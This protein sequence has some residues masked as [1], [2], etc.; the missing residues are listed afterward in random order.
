MLAAGDFDLMRPYFEMYRRALP[1]ARERCRKFCSHEGAFFPE[2]MWFWGAYLEDNYGWSDTRAPSLPVH[3]SQNQY[4]RRHHSSGLEVAC[5]ALVYYRFTGDTE[6]L[7]GTA[8]PLADA[9]LDYYAHQFPRHG[10]RLHISPAQVIEQWWVAENPLPDIAGLQ[11]VLRELL[12][13]PTRT[14]EGASFFIPAESWKGPPRNSENPE[15]YA[16]FSYHHCVIGSQDIETGRETFRRRSHTHDKGWA[17]DG[18]QAALLGLTDAACESVTHRLT[19]PSAYDR[20]PAFWG[21]EFDWIPDQD[22]GGS[23]SHAFQLMAMQSAADNTLHIAPAWPREWTL[24]CQ[25]HSPGGVCRLTP[26]SAPEVELSGP[27][28]ETLTVLTH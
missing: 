10:G 19:T 24:D 13:L 9:L 28:V 25:L 17:Q 1:Q 7:R 26:G 3:L 6:F 11:A 5:H 8:L 18:I 21:P 23:A 20:F 16:V 22:Q 14:A 27:G 15:L 4:I 12:A 2:T